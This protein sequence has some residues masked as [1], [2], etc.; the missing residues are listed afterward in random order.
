MMNWL[1]SPTFTCGKG[2]GVGG[3]NDLTG[4]L[5]GYHNG[6]DGKGNKPAPIVIPAP[7]PAPIVIPAPVVPAP[8]YL[9]KKGKAVETTVDSATGEVRPVG[10]DA[11]NSVA[12]QAMKKIK[13]ATKAAALLK[14]ASADGAGATAAAVP[15]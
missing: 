5:G 15:K 7:V 14:Q 13:E 8:I 2:I 3:S 4:C 10:T 9:D 12:I 11:K 6:D 1:T